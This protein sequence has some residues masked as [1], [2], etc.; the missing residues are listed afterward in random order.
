LSGSLI[1][2]QKSADHYEAVFRPDEKNLLD[3][4]N[5]AQSLK[6]IGDVYLLLSENQKAKENFQRALEIL[7]QLK[8]QNALGEWDKKLFDEVQTALQ[9]P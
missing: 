4:R 5:L 8:T 6:S 1:A 2:F 9:K 3:R 7:N